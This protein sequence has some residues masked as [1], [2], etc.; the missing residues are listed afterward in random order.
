VKDVAIL[1]IEIKIRLQTIRKCT[2][3]CAELSIFVHPLVH[4]WVL[5]KKT[6]N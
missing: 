4:F 3:G 5:S 6:E 1:K 2:S